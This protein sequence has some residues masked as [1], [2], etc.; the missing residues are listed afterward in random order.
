M[1]LYEGNFALL[2][3]AFEATG[4]VRACAAEGGYFLVVDVTPSGLD[5]LEFCGRLIDAAGVAG[6]PMRSFYAPGADGAPPVTHLV[7]YAICKSRESVQRAVAALAD[8]R[9]L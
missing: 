5:D 9:S 6:M 3:E 1:Q 2:R 4:L 7:R 8:M